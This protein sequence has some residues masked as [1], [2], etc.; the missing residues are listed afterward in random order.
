MVFFKVDKKDKMDMLNSNSENLPAQWINSDLRYFDFRVLG[1]FD[2]LMCDPPWDI[3]MQ[4][5][6]P[7]LCPLFNFTPASLRNT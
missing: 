3:H 5:K 1:K 7:F 4:V 6:T 2:V